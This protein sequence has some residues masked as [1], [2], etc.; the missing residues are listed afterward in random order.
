MAIWLVVPITA[1]PLTSSFAPGLFVPTP[2]FPVV[3]AT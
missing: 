2:T 3:E 1:V